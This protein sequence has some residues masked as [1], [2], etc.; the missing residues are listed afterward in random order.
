VD[1]VK[2][3]VVAETSGGSITLEDVEGTVQAGTSGGSIHAAFGKCPEKDCRLETSGGS[4]TVIAPEELKADL[5][6]ST[7]GGRVSTEF[8]VTVSGEI[9]PEEIR[10]AL[11]GGGPLLLLRTSGGNIRIEKSKR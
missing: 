7:S 5:D 1:S 10:A 8:P 2:G 9:R 4:I 11:N 6:A 3:D